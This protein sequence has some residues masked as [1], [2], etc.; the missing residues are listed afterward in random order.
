MDTQWITPRAGS[1]WIG[2]GELW[3]D[4]EGNE[5]NRFDCSMWFEPDSLNYNW[6]YD[7]KTEQGVFTF[8]ESNAGWIDSWHQPD[9]VT[10]H[11]E[12][13]AWGLFTIAHAYEVPGSPAWGWRSILS[14]RPDASL[15]LQMTNIA[16]WGE[17]GRAVRMIFR[18]TDQ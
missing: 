6:L 4:P 1:K 11:Y 5:V 16:P 9:I 7:G 2:K 15:V 17:E 8:H 18:A 3:L 10:C 12:P 13:G 14:E